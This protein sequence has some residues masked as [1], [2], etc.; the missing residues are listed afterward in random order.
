MNATIISVGDEILSGDVID[1]NSKWLAK[2]LCKQGVSVKRIIVVGDDKDE[3]GEAISNC[4]TDFIFVIGGLGPTHDDITREGVAKGVGCKLERNEEAERILREKWGIEG[5]L[6]RMADMPSGSKSIE[7]PVGVAPG[8]IIRNIIVL[9]GMPEEMKAM[10]ESI[11]PMFFSKE[12]IKGEEWIETERAEHEI[13]D[14]LNEAVRRF[15]DVKI[16]SY[17]YIKRGGGKEG[18][19]LR[20]KLES[21]NENSLKEAK[22]WLKEALELYRS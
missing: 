22:R 1:T 12:G 8:F 13:L 5:D 6:L 10:F 19:R 16:G 17:P 4:S 7:N 20:I 2:K 18:Y 15:A 21:L 14:I 3:I 11:S 9:P